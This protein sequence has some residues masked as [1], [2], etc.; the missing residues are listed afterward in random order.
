MSLGLQVYFLIG[1]TST[2]GRAKSGITINLCPHARNTKSTVTLHGRFVLP[3]TQLR[4]VDGLTPVARP[5]WEN[6]FPLSITIFV[7][8]AM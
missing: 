3:V 6:D 8:V 4:G 7:M 5:I 1:F 2:L